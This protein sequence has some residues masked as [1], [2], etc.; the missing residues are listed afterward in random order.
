MRD[1]EE[2]KAILGTAIQPGE[3][4]IYV[5]TAAITTGMTQAGKSLVGIP[6]EQFDIKDMKVTEE[7]DKAKRLLS[8]KGFPANKSGKALFLIHK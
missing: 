3:N 1:E 5:G 4:P 6:V 8:E 2:Q 7:F